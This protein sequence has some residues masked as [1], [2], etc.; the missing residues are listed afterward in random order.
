MK[1]AIPSILAA[2][3][4]LSACAAPPEATTAP[5]AATTEATVPE[6]SLAPTTQAT[7]PTVPPTTE[8]APVL[9]H[10]L[11]GSI[12]EQP[13]A[14]RPV[15]VV[16]NNIRDAQPMLGIGGA[17]ILFEHVAEGGGIITRMLAVYSAPEQAGVIGSV[18]S[19]RTYLIDLARNFGAPIVHCGYSPYAKEDLENTGYPSYN[20]FFQGKYF[21]RD[22]GRLSSGYALEHTMM[23]RGEDLAKGL[24][25]SGL[26]MTASKDHYGM[27]FSE[28]VTLDGASTREITVQF[29]NPYGKYT[30]M[31][32]DP[33]KDIYTGT[34]K[35]SGGQMALA[36]GN[37]G[38]AVEFRNVLILHA[39]T[40][41]NGY[42]EF[43]RL[44]GEGT[45]YFACGGSYVPIRWQRPTTADS[46]T[47]TLE[48]GTP[49]TFGV[50]KTYAA[51]LPTQSP[52]VIFE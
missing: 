9:R 11:N 16:V 40:H 15:A 5:T 19:A 12:L 13:L 48:D 51:I 17:D 33:A 4:L 35:W 43:A 32:Y 38:E 8:A 6:T 28:T 27:D 23:I 50:G 18:R 41:S 29:Y 1:R 34:Q 22:S 14:V 49:I 47:Y 24:T 46:F 3:L 26:D 7:V 25:E 2:C 20:Q 39:E 52:A 30:V 44:H 42:H 36:D 31:T 21:Y 10:P 45:G 37:T